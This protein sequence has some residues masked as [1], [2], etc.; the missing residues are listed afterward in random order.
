LGTAISIHN[1]AIIITSVTEVAY[2]T[3][4]AYTSEMST[5]F[6][7]TALHPIRQNVL[8]QLTL[9]HTTFY[10]TWRTNKY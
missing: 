1:F 10:N 5:H 3:Y 6:H 4:I 2:D 9:W 8:A 7:C